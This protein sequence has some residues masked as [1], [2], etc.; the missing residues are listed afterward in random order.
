MK[1]AKRLR[2][3]RQNTS[4]TRPRPQKNPLK[5][6]K[7]QRNNHFHTRTLILVKC[8]RSSEEIC[9]PI[10]NAASVDMYPKPSAFQKNVNAASTFICVRAQKNNLVFSQV[11]VVLV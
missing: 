4:K 3:P 7:N 11:P 10:A 1:K 5:N 8:N 6:L 9:K 2:K